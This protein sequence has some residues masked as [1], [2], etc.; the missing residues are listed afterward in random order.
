MRASIKLRK[1][2]SEQYS[3]PHR[4][5]VAQ[6]INRGLVFDY[7]WYLQQPFSLACSDFKSCYDRIFHSAS[8][9]ALQHLGIYLPSIYIILETIQCMSY[10]AR[11]ASGDYNI[12][13]SGDNVTGKFWHLIMGLC[14]GNGCAPQLWSIISY[15]VLSEIRN[16]GFDIHFVNSYTTEIS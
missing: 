15:I 10:T 11:T 13:Y 12:T 1:F 14:Q 3:R 2:S 5:S 8:S 4:S 9:L 6:K 7:Q 16:Q